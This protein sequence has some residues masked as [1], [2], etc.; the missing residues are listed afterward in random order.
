MTTTAYENTY[1]NVAN[2]KHDTADLAAVVD[3][4][5]SQSSPITC[6]AIG[7]AIFG[8]NYTEGYMT[9]HYVNHLS[10]MLKHLREGGFIRVDKVNGEPIEVE[11]DE[12]RRT[13]D[14]GNPQFIR[15]HDDEGNEY[16]MSNPKYD[17]W[18]SCRTPGE[19]VKV[20]KT[21]VP[22]IKVYTWVA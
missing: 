6:K 15:V 3:F 22:K 2:A 11:S 16:Q 20:K 13:D 12:Y 5:R 8:K 10:Q 9:R 21:I 7:V 14:E 1:V 18:R 19:W 17:M 4:L